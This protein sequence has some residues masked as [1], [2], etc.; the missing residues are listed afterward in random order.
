MT[1]MTIEQ[2][3]RMHQRRPFQPF[4]IRIADGRSLPVEHP[5]VL[6]ITPPGR[7]IGVGL[8]DGTVEIVDVLLITT[9]KPRSNGA[10]RRS[11]SR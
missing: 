4:D 9:L 3:R 7:T 5:E 1:A 10:S 6:A 11:R 2:L 8:A